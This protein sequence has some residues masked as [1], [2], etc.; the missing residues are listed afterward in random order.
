M[1]APGKRGRA[2]GRLLPI[3]V[4]QGPANY[5]SSCVH[6]DGH[7]NVAIAHVP[8]IEVQT[9]SGKSSAI[10][11]NRSIG[12][13][14]KLPDRKTYENVEWSRF[15][16]L[17]KLTGRGQPTLVSR[18]PRGNVLAIG[19]SVVLQYRPCRNTPTTIR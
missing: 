9:R 10:P 18:G 3:A 17:R 16:P 14:A 4:R 7:S 6:S 5:G 2:L 12:Q 8:D 11:V 19:R 1:S 13:S 15:D